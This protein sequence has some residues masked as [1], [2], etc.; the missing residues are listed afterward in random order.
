MTKNGRTERRIDHLIDEARA[1]LTAITLEPS[2]EF[3]QR[4]RSRNIQSIM[5]ERNKM[6][7]TLG[8]VGKELNIDFDGLWEWQKICEGL[9]RWVRHKEIEK[10]V[11]QEEK[12]Q[13]RKKKREDKKEKI[14]R[15]KLEKESNND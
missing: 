3:C 10:V 12:K 5:E 14:I 9:I 4:C 6:L 7:V 8:E 13:L 2:F 15:R 11:Q 1:E